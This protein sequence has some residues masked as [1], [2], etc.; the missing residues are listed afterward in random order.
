MSTHSSSMSQLEAGHDVLVDLRG[1]RSE[2][3]RDLRYRMR[4]VWLPARAARESN[5]QRGFDIDVRLA[6]ATDCADRYRARHDCEFC[7]RWR[8]QM[9][10]GQK[11]FRSCSQGHPVALEGRQT[12]LLP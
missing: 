1:I 6:S 8:S 3:P 10:R 2:C 9:G 11:L 7:I 5:A 12:T 4:R